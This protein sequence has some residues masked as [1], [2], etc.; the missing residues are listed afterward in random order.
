MPIDR[1]MDKEDVVGEQRKKKGT[2]PFVT[3][4]DHEGTVLSE[5]SQTEKTDSVRS[6]S[7][8]IS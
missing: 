5:I 2:M 8:T 1:C 4:M 3:R 6:L 7:S